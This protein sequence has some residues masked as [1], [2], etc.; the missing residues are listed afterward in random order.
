MIRTRIRPLSCALVVAA[1]AVPT[2]RAQ[3]VPTPVADTS[4]TQ[5]PQAVLL[6]VDVILTRSQSGKV[7]GS[8]P[9]ALLIT[10]GSGT[11]TSLRVGVDVPT[12]G[13]HTVESNGT[14]TRTPEYKNI[15][16]SIDC[17]PRG[18]P[19]DGRYPIHLSIQDTSV[20]ATD[21]SSPLPKIVEPTAFRTTSMSAYLFARE[22]Q[23]YE[24]TTGTDKVTGETIKA[25]VRITVVK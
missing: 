17:I 7:I 18:F 23:L 24:L 4:A 12:G 14:T 25:E 5:K 6:K 10:S 20:H 21:A 15:G 13:Q 16:T 9:Y 8:I 22:G 19:V 3:Q 2:A 11:P 1:L